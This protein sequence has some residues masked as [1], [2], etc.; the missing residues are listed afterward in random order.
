MKLNFLQNFLKETLHIK[1]KITHF[2]ENEKNIANGKI[3]SEK[4]LRRNQHSYILKNL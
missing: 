1:K 2:L 3:K 4:K